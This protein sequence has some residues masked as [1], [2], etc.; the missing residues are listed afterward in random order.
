KTF[1]QCKLDFSERERHAEMYALHQDLLRLRR[2]DPVFRV[3]RPRGV[4]G[5]VLAAQ[6]FVL[7]FFASDGMDRLLV[8]NLGGDLRLSPVP[9]PLL[10][11]PASL[12]AQ[13]GQRWDVRWSSDDIRYGGCGTPPLDTD[14][15]WRI[16]AEAA[17]VLAP[18]T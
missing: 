14:D 15:G 8:V 12:H 18:T 17:V 1:E 5:A 11:P 2:E 10:A 7:R 3:Q 9:E 16:P 4:D 13:G 6:A